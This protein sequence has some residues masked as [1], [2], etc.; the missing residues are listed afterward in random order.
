[1]VEY[2]RTN[3][4]VVD[5]AIQRELEQT[6]DVATAKKKTIQNLGK[7]IDE[8]KHEHEVIQK[9]AARF[10]VYL[11]SN[12]ITH[13]NDATIEYLEHLIKDEKTKANYSGKPT[14][15]L[16]RLEKDLASYKK[17]VDAMQGSKSKIKPFENG[18]RPLDEAGVANVVKSLYELPHYGADLKKL[19]QVVGNAY[20][21]NFRER[22][23]R[24]SRRQHWREEEAEGSYRVDLDRDYSGSRWES[25]SG[26]ARKAM[27]KRSSQPGGFSSMIDDVEREIRDEKS[28]A[29]RNSWAPSRSNASVLKKPAPANSWVNEKEKEAM[30]AQPAP[31]PLAADDN[32]FWPTG[33]SDEKSAAPLQSISGWDENAGSSAGPSRAPPPYSEATAGDAA[34]PQIVNGVQIVQ[35]K[36]MWLKLRKRFSKKGE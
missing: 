36:G 2:S 1:M 30:E 29:G 7:Q 21:S 33:D 35:K 31:E 13:Y 12:S 5:G 8:L 20:E 14:P 32:D 22:P 11:K 23:Y 25:V 24:I 9:A 15:R 6:G 19:A 4:T 16:E 26:A 34:Q 27:G 28:P 3:T 18:H 17:F 10:S